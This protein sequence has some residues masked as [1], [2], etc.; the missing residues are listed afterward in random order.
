MF[1]PSFV[2]FGVV[3]LFDASHNTNTEPLTPFLPKED[4]GEADVLEELILN[5]DLAVGLPLLLL[6]M[7]W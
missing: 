2:I 6:T 7:L 5:K 1:R 4:W 3:H